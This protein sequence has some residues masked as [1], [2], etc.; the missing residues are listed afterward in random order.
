LGLSHAEREP[1]YT[2]ALLH[3]VG[4]VGVSDA[5]LK[6]P[7]ALLPEEM[8]LMRQHPVLGASMISFV[9][10]RSDVV[11]AVRHHHE[12]WNGGGYPDGLSGED[13]PKMARIVAVADAFSAL[14]HNRPYRPGVSP[15]EAQKILEAGA[16]QQWD[17]AY[18]AALLRGYRLAVIS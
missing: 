14:V 7:R 8:L 2:A 15:R 4:K 13:I 18:V 11:A 17:P 3:D 12:A 10:G 6:A 1:L 5:I 16:G 9:R